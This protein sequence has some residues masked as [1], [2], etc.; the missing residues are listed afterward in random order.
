MLA[1]RLVPCALAALLALA[2]AGTAQAATRAHYRAVAKEGI[3]D[4]KRHWWSASKRWYDDRLNDGDAY[5]LATVWS[6]VPLF[7]AI[8]GAA[9]GDP[10]K[11]RL[12][13]VRSF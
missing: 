7:E 6:I 5:P 4:A 13:A 12:K 9:I 8:D 1:R 2:A 3:A 11:A 10:T